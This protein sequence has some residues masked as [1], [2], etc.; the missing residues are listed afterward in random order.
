MVADRISYSSYITN[1][2]S[3]QYYSSA[4]DYPKAYASHFS[5]DSTYFNEFIQY[6]EQVSREIGS[7]ADDNVFSHFPEYKLLSVYEDDSVHRLL[8]PAFI[9]QRYPVEFRD[10]PLMSGALS[11]FMPVEKNGKKP[12]SGKKNVESRKKKNSLRIMGD[13]VLDKEKLKDFLMAHNDSIDTSYVEKLVKIYIEEAARE[14]VNHDVAFVQMCHE[15]DFLKYTGVVKPK[16]N[17]FCGLGTVNDDTPGEYFETAE[18]GI[19]AHIQHLKAYASKQDLKHALVDNRF[20]FVKRGI[21]PVVEKLTG[22]WATDP[23]YDRKIKK[24]FKRL[25]AHTGRQLTRLSI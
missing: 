11:V 10:K 20:Y 14:G 24:L 7:P 17:N 1:T 23:D 21:A 12:K 15:T 22:R 8:L 16:Q 5:A 9:T 18:K 25:E 2:F 13:G 4:C 6:L 19:R 3:S